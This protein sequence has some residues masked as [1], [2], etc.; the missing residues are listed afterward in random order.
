MTINTIRGSSI[1]FAQQ[2]N[3]TPIFA[4]QNEVLL[5]SVFWGYSLSKVINLIAINTIRGSSIIF[6]QQNN[7]TPIFAQQNEVLLGSAFWGYSLSIV[8][9]LTAINT[10]QLVLPLARTALSEKKKP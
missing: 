4:Q 1:I 5:G 3:A 8:I 2:N 10:C 6:A 9:N 7:A